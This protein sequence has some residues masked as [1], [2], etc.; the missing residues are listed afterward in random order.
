MGAGRPRETQRGKGMYLTP[1]LKVVCEQLAALLAHGDAEASDMLVAH[2]ALLEAAFP[3][4]YKKIDDDVRAFD[5]EAAGALLTA[6]YA[7]RSAEQ[8]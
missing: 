8:T 3:L 7:H 2:A 6:S 1:E 5:Y 4:H